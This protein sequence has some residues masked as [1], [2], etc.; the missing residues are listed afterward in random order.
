[1]FLAPYRHGWFR[2][3]GEKTAIAKTTTSQVWVSCPFFF[4][5]VT[6]VSVFRILFGFSGTLLPGIVTLAWKRLW[7]KHQTPWFCGWLLLYAVDRTQRLRERHKPFRFQ[8][9]QQWQRALQ[10]WGIK[11]IN[12]QL[13]SDIEWRDEV[14][15]GEG[16]DG[17]TCFC[18]WMKLIFRQV[19]LQISLT[20][21]SFWNC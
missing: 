9:P 11:E 5:S 19:F 3:E 4:L 17:Y 16:S 12:F 14:G 8:S 1:M 6:W 18:T 15:A 2:S 10:L 13:N 7:Q 21:E 20:L